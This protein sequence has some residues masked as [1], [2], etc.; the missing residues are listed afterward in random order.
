MSNKSKRN[1]FLFLLIM[2]VI[3]YCIILMF[4]SLIPESLKWWIYILAAFLFVFLLGCYRN[5]QQAVKEDNKYDR[6]K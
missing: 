6:L 3:A 2:E 1:L 5:Y 4:K